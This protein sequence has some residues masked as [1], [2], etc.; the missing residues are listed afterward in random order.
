MIRFLEQL[1]P[2]LGLRIYEYPHAVWPG[3]VHL[4]RTIVVQASLTSAFVAEVM[5]VLRHVEMAPSHRLSFY[6]TW[7]SLGAP[8]DLQLGSKPP[9]PSAQNP[10]AHHHRR[11]PSPYYHA[12]PPSVTDWAV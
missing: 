8:Y 12:A 6:A 3:L 5:M 11:P 7:T 10:R 1:A 2:H 9:D 4:P